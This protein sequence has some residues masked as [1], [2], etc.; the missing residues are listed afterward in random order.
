MWEKGE[1]FTGTT[2]KYTWTITRGVGN[3]GRRWG[4]G[5]GGRDECGDKAENCT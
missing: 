4:G 1:G 2:I 3:W 5:W